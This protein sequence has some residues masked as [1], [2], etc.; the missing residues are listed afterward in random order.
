MIHINFSVR[1]QQIWNATARLLIVPTVEGEITVREGHIPLISVIKSGELVI[2]DTNGK[3]YHYAITK[4]VVDVHPIPPP[5]SPIFGE[6]PLR[7]ATPTPTLPQ[8]ERAI[9]TEVILLCD[10]AIESEAIDIEAEG[11]AVARAEA[12]MASGEVFEDIS[13]LT[14]PLEKELNRIRVKGRRM[15]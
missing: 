15:R 1:D 10:D 6:E 14:S 3:K 8:G 2:E 7:N 4:G 12:A 5:T 13:G 11:H 9:Q